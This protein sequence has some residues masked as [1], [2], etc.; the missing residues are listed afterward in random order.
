[1]LG[2]LRP[3]RQLASVRRAATVLAVL[4]LAMMV[5][6]TAPWIWLSILAAATAGMACLLAGAQTRALL[7]R[8]GGP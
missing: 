2:S 7:Y 5:F 4:S 8:R 3:V 6:V 1:M